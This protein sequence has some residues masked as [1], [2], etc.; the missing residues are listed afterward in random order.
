M[1]Q[2][3]TE[4]AMALH[5]K[6][7]NCAQAVLLPFCEELGVDRSTAMRMAEGFGA[8]MGGRRQTCGALSGAVM[9]AGLSCCDGA[10]EQPTTKQA[11]YAVCKQMSERFVKECGSGIC[12]ELKGEATGKPLASCEN[13]IAWGVRLAAECLK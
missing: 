1:I 2:E 9:V 8:G 10:V 11:T 5:A 4:E 3:K 12:T 7:H 6:G 13:C